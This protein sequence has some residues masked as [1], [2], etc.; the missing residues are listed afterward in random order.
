MNINLARASLAARAWVA[1]LVLIAWTSPMSG[2]AQRIPGHPPTN[3]ASL[4]GTVRD[5]RTKLGI[6]GAKISLLR[7]GV[8]LR[9]KWTDAEGIFRFV[10]LTPASYELKAEKEGFQAI[11]LTSL[12]INGPETRDLAL[13]PTTGETVQTKGDRKS[14]V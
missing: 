11:Y 8:V 14:V 3:T 9:E 13:E 6:L 1:F 5:P 2:Q 10:D 7:A 4:Q 12:Q